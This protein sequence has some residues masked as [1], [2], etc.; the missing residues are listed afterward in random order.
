MAKKKL[1]FADMIGKKK[2]NVE[3]KPKKKNTP[4]ID[5]PKELVANMKEFLDAKKQEKESKSI[6]TSA[7]ASIIEFCRAELDKKAFE[8]NYSNSYD[9]KAGTE[10]DNIKI[11]KFISAD[12]FSVSQDEE[13]HG[14]LQELFGEEYDKIIEEETS[15]KMKE[16]VF[17]DK[18]LQAK[19]VEAVGD[20]FDDFFETTSTYKVKK[21]LAD[22]I[23]TLAKDQGKLDQIRTLI[24]QKKPALK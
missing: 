22:R 12:A 10:K 15:I 6:K 21:G 5:L 24:T 23:H 3:E 7:E 16:E 17:Q 4:I 14:Q 18:K 20:N 13:V 1:N 8:G 9:I 19:M 2:T 11:V